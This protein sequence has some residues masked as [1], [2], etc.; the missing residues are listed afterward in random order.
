[1]VVI[2]KQ[3]PRD[4]ALVRELIGESHDWD[5]RNQLLAA[6]ADASHVANWQRAEG[7]KKDMPK[8][9]PRPGVEPI[10]QYGGQAVSIEEMRDRLERRRLH[11][12]PDPPT[13]RRDGRGRFIKN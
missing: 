8:P 9:I 11:A 6:I 5:L 2:V 12:V 10:R 1:M 13:R 3:S 7:K 4:S